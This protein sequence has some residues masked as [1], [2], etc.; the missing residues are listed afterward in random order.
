[1]EEL[2][3]GLEMTFG[4]VG[5]SE[6]IDGD[7]DLSCPDEPEGVPDDAAG[8]EDVAR[9]SKF[10]EVREESDRFRSMAVMVSEDEAEVAIEVSDG[11][12]DRG[13]G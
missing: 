6:L 10:G 12:S 4:G 7:C 11:F 1:V 13:G 3:V 2:R 9:I 8:D 5:P